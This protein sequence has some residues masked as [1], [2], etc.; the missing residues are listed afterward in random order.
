MPGL[1]DAASS[2][3]T[4]RGLPNRLAVG[5]PD[6]R[7]SARTCPRRY[8]ANQKRKSRLRAPAE[9]GARRSSS[10]RPSVRGAMMDHADVVVIG[11]GGLGAATAFYLARLGVERVVVVDKHD[12]ASQTSP[13]AAGMLS[14]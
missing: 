10:P 5:A 9:C 7:I 11:S 6:R 1:S 14:H 13:R 2:P 8:Y 12:L 3:S 4:P